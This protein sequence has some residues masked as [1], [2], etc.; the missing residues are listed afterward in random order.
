MCQWWVYAISLTGQADKN[1]R[2]DKAWH[3]IVTSYCPDQES[4]GENVM[5]LIFGVNQ[6]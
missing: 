1:T 4:D 5:V 3:D 2:L 6:F